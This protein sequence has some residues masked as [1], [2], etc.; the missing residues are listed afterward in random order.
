MFAACSRFTEAGIK[1]RALALR[2][3]QPPVVEIDEPEPIEIEEP[4]VEAA[5]ELAV[6]E[7]AEPVERVPH[8]ITYKE[9]ERWVCRVTG[10]K[11]LDIISERRSRELVLARQ[12]IAYLAVVYT[13]LSMPQIGRLM[14]GRDHTTILHAY[15]T[16]PVK[17]AKARASRSGEKAGA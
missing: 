10:F 17:R 11:R 13:T 15:R 16:Y 14:G 7:I 6:E 9:I 3:L 1:Q 4:E 5:P 8:K 2:A 12:A